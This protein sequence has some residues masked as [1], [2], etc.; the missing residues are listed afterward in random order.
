MLTH[1]HFIFFL[2]SITVLEYVF[3]LLWVILSVILCEFSMCTLKSFIL[4][5]FS[6]NTG[7]SI[8]FIFLLWALTPFFSYYPYAHFFHVFNIFNFL[9]NPFLYPYYFLNCAVFFFHLLF[10]LSKHL[11]CLFPIML[12]LIYF[13]IFL[14]FFFSYS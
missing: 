1:A 3:M 8:C 5:K 10:Y 14:E 11:L 9:L 7:F 2:P 12:F 4:G 13:C 6:V